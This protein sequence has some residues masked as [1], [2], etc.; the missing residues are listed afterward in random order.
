MSHIPINHN[1]RPLY[2]VL[3]GLIGAYLVVAGVLGFVESK[4][5]DFFGTQGATTVVG[6]KGNMAWSV[7]S[8]AT[9]ALIVLGVVLGRNLDVKINTV[10]SLV[11]MTVGTAMLSLLRT[12]LNVFGGSMTTVIIVYTAGMLLLAAALYGKVGTSEEAEAE[13]AFRHA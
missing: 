3:A 10:T 12:D 9:G 13:E 8:L 7:F 1:L 5:L 4:D 2:R 11:L 6:T